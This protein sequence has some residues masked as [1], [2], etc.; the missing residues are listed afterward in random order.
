[1]SQGSRYL[2][3]KPMRHWRYCVGEKHKED[4]A[5]GCFCLEMLEVEP[6]HALVSMLCAAA[7]LSKACKASRFFVEGPSIERGVHNTR[8]MGAMHNNS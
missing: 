5:F 8:Q 2:Q 6:S 7:S 3:A 4:D 1:M